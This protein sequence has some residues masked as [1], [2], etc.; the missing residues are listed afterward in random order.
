MKVLVIGCGRVGSSIATRMADDGHDV[1]VVDEDAESLQRLP[2]SWPGRF[3]HGHGL[4]LEVLVQ[5]GIQDADSVVVAT[6]GDNTNI[7]IAQVAQKRFGCPCVVTR[8][9]DPARAAFYA[10]QGLRTIC[11]T[12]T[13]IDAAMSAIC[14]TPGRGE[15]AS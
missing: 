8:V 13:A 6:D 14:E 9:L 5:A 7:V 3:L 2:E 1:T 10:S 11:A 12:S 4:D 15:R